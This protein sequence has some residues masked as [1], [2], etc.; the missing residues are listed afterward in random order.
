[1]NTKAALIAAAVGSLLAAG[2]GPAFAAEGATEKCYGNVKAG[3][4]DC[5]TA[6]HSCAGQAKTDNDPA[7]WKN[8]PEGTCEK[9]GGSLTA[10]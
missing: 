3:A 8:V 9:S 6:A 10:K 2:A 4:N 7:E 1:M 5:A